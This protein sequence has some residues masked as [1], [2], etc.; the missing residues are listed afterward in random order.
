MKNKD[1]YKYHLELEESKNTVYANLLRGRIADFYK[2]NGIRINTIM[3]NINAL[4]K[5]YFVLENGVV[6]QDENKIPVMNE[7]RLFDEYVSKFD[8]LM[9]SDCTIVF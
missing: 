6:K 5:D 2:N 1:L 3:S 9:E 8:A 7:G 4:Q